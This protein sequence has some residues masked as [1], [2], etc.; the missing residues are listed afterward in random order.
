[1][2]APEIE[3]TSQLVNDITVS[4]NEQSNGAS[5]INSAIQDLNLIIQQYAATAEEMARNSK[6]LKIEAE[7]L[8]RSI[9]F[10]NVEEQ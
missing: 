3:Q 8:E 6:V 4:S 10:F 9:K 1:H 7:E 5:Q 2:L